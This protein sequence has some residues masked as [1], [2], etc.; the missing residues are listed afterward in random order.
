MTQRIQGRES[1]SGDPVLKILF[2]GDSITDAFRRP[3]ELNPAFQLGNGYAFLAASHLA[4]HY[5]EC[6][7][8]FFNRGISGQGVLALRKRWSRDAIEIRPDV[9][10][11]LIGVNDTIQFQKGA[12]KLSDPEFAEHYAWLVDS[13]REENPSMAVVLMEPFLLEVG[14][15]TRDWIR[16]LE[17]RQKF[18]RDYAAHCGA[19]FI[20]LQ[21]LFE[22]A[23]ERAPAE[24][25][26]YD[27]IHPTH[28]GFALVA[29]A[30]LSAVQPFLNLRNSDL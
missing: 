27:G 26:A 15:V 5:P 28:A 13:L 22:A 3:E 30:W 7:W 21:S 23:S 16:H 4:L 2:Q 8:E 12:S 1:G 14:E 19:A 6:C 29:E 18:V 17:P 25:W 20:P 9:L 11:L 24:F 10:S